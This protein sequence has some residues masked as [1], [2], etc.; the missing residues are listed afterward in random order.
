MTMFILYCRR[1]R[2]ATAPSGR[3]GIECKTYLELVL[4]LYI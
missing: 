2:L 1:P 4:Y 3:T